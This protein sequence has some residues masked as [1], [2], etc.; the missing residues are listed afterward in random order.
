MADQQ[1]EYTL[2]S[3]LPSD[4]SLHSV[5]SRTCKSNFT[6]CYNWEP[7]LV[8]KDQPKDNCEKFN[9]FERKPGASKGKMTEYEKNGLENEMYKTKNKTPKNMSIISYNTQKQLSEEANN[10][11]DNKHNKIKNSLKMKENTSRYRIGKRELNQLLTSN[12]FILNERRRRKSKQN[13]HGWRRPDEA[14][15]KETM[16]YQNSIE[17]VGVRLLG[18]YPKKRM[19][20]ET[21]NWPQKSG[22]GVNS[23]EEKEE[24]CYCKM[25]V[26]VNDASK[27]NEILPN[28]KTH[29]PL[30]TKRPET[31]SVK[32]KNIL[33]KGERLLQSENPS[34]MSI[35]VLDE[36]LCKVREK[37]KHCSNCNMLQIGHHPSP[38]QYIGQE[39]KTQK[40]ATMV[41]ELSFQRN[42]R[43]N[44]K[45]TDFFQAGKLTKDYES[46]SKETRTGKMN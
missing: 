36:E 4:Q 15:V 18:N 42:L 26:F 31:E 27:Q 46:D 41:S 43:T 34:N 37:Y 17:K 9:H 3:P 32:G 22:K 40:K 8:Y 7:G 45:K 5:C 2:A 1:A 33:H 21:E 14:E 28:E 30:G 20:Y 16:T 23:G 44:P 6:G 12:A 10:N 29:L 39:S 25:S 11:A 38:G 24:F 19:L 35:T 13:L